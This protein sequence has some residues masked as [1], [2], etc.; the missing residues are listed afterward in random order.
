MVIVILRRPLYHIGLIPKQLADKLS[1]LPPHFPA[2]NLLALWPT[3]NFKI[4]Q[5]YNGL[6]DKL[7]INSLQEQFN[8]KEQLE[9]ELETM[10]PAIQSKNRAIQESEAILMN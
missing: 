3:R 5:V 6:S 9:T 8:L 1:S 7:L 10:W 2:Y 4:W